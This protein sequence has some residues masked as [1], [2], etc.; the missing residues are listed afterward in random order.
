MP[1]G[2][3]PF[4]EMTPEDYAAIGLKCGLE[5]HQQLLTDT[6]TFCRCPAGRYSDDYDAEILRHM[7]PTLSELGEYDGTALMEKKTRKNIYYRLNHET[8]CTYEFD[9][10]PPFFMSD[11]A[12]DIAL[13][14]GLLLRL[15]M[16]SELHIARKQYLDGSIPTGF[17]RTTI[18]GV[19]G[20][21][22][23]K[24]RR[25]HVRQLGLEEDSCREVSD[26]G[27]DRVYITDRLGM[28]L[29]EVVTEPEMFTP[30]ECAEV[31]EV[32]RM[33]CRSTH[34]VRRGYGATRQDVNVSVRGGTRIEIKGVPQITRIPRLIYNEARRQCA[35]LEIRD[36]LARRGVTPESFESS[37]HDVTGLMTKAQYEPIHSAL[38]RGLRI[39]CVTLKGFAG[40]LNTVTQ[41]HTTFATE[42]SDRVRV[43][44]CLTELPNLVQSDTAAETL[45]ARD[46]KQLRRKTRAGESDAML[47][48][49][50]DEQDA[51]CAC[52]EIAN[53]A[54]EAAA[55]VPSDTRQAH[56]D[57][58]TGFERVLPGPERMYPDTD[59]PPIEIKA[60]RLERI[61]AQ[62]PP[63]V[64][65]R[66]ARY[67][68]MKLPAETV[69]PLC[70]SPRADLF[71]RIV[72]DLGVNPVFTAVVL[73]QRL[74]AMRR[75]GLQVEYLNDEDLYEV[76]T[77]H[78]QGR[79]AREGV[80][81][82]IEQMLRVPPPQETA[83]E[84]V[85]STL[86]YMGITPITDDELPPAIAAAHGRLSKTRF[87]TRTQTSRYLTGQLMKKLIGRVEGRDLAAAVR[88][89]ID[90][91]TEHLASM[92]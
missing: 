40:L 41:E 63:Y 52:E 37:D 23:Y 64:W 5:V 26:I 46:W 66:E 33:L 72:D 53:R 42:F 84:R 8:V 78:A 15:N 47:L 27:H 88:G 34:K 62:L 59:L 75:A 67:L 4:A 16:V 81:A 74:K 30:Q 56:K 87:P 7:R 58:T 44:A 28:P 89:Q 2:F 31:C 17:Q 69:R 9:D 68:A 21:L 1:S 10:T 79:L 70:V 86:D 51:R 19:S 82:V 61:A 60:E 6:K 25:I 85:A 76:F 83:A 45:A 55:G 11:Q 73:F 50:G 18:V 36:E 38:E 35:L 32:I 43:I 92:A 29:I 22:P 54:R 91:E 39:R 24:D 65:E 77:A 80:P 20:W 71:D 12:L 3:K 48:V 13:E 14:I 49:W 57:N 90:P